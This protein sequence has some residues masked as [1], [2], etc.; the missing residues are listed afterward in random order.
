MREKYSELKLQAN[1]FK[2]APAWLLADAHDFTNDSQIAN[3]DAIT[4]TALTASLTAFYVVRHSNYSSEAS[5]SYKMRVSTSVGHLEL[6]HLGGS[7]VLHG[8]DSKIMTTDFLAGHAHIL[9]STTEIFTWQAYTKKT[10]I[11]L[12]AGPD[13]DNEVAFKTTERPHIMEGRLDGVKSKNGILHVRWKT[14]RERTVFRAGDVEVY[15]MGMFETH[16]GSCFL[17]SRG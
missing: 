5:T 17:P 15:L 11:L 7:L 6:P 2:V 16:L 12:Y 13:E 1:F 8:R 3:T 4:V 10:V 9:Y 14:Q